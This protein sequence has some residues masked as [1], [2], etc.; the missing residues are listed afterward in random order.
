MNKVH[1]HAV[2]SRKVWKRR[3]HHS[4][5]HRP[6]LLFSFHFSCSQSAPAHITTSQGSR[7]FFASLLFFFFF[8]YQ[9]QSLSDHDLWVQLLVLVD[10]C[11]CAWL[12]QNHRKSQVGLLEV[13]FT[14]FP[15]GRANLFATSSQLHQPEKLKPAGTWER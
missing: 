8:V 15:P 5:S 4:A 11:F 9:S 14:T 10:G 13:P 7:M 6:A 3:A 1:P 12:K 2:P